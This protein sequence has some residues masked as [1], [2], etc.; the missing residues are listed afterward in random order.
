MR[1]AISKFQARFFF[2]RP[3]DTILVFCLDDVYD[4]RG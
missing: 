2:S 1:K 4:S 3:L